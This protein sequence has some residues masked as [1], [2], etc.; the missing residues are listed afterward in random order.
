MARCKEYNKPNNK[1]GILELKK[2]VCRQCKIKRL[3]SVRDVERT[4]RPSS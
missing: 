2:G 3:Q 4:S 1:Y